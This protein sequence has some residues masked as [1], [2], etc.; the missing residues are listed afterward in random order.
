MDSPAYASK[1]GFDEPRDSG[2]TVHDIGAIA[3]AYVGCVVQRKM[4]ESL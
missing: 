4:A 3:T 2:G 1:N